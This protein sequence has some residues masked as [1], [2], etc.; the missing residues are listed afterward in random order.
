M[1]VLCLLGIH[2]HRPTAERWTHDGLTWVVDRCRRC[3][4]RRILVP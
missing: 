4:R 2:A 1:N 3:A